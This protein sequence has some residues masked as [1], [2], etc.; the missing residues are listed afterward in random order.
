MRFYYVVNA[1]MP[2]EKAHGIQIAKMCEAFAEAGADIVLMVPRR[3]GSTEDLQ[4]F[5]ALRPSIPLIRL[6]VPDFYT[7]G[8]FGFFMSSLFFM[9][10]YSF[11]LLRRRIAGERF[12]IY[13]IDMDTFSF[14][15]LPLFGMCIT[16][17]H[18]PKK[19]TL[20]QKFF[21]HRVAGVISTTVLTKTALRNTFAF[22]AQRMIVEPNG[23]DVN[24]FASGMSKE[25]ARQK[26]SLPG[27]Q[28]IALY[29]GRV[30]AWKG[31]EVL[32]KACERLLASS[33]ECYVVG[34]T[35]E[36][37]EKLF[38][39]KLPR[40]MHCMGIKEVK[41]IPLW[42]AASDVALVV[43]TAQNID[44][45]RYTSPMK[46]FE[47]VA[48]RI[49]IVA[50]GTPALKEVLTEDDVLFYEPDNSESLAQNIIDAVEK[51]H[52][53]AVRTAHAFRKVQQYT[54]QKRAQRILAFCS[55]LS[56]NTIH[57]A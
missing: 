34:G 24:L 29:V 55:S 44:S 14:T 53:S 38:G 4:S 46:L 12:V 11:F 15:F 37:L 42:L 5:Y 8:R 30:Y 2:N 21:F 50:S 49:P 19:G 33:I 32:P 56:E 36:E 26:L 54:W 52:E 57:A 41:E 6:W 3:G 23:V 17:M 39:G 27:T 25:D 22:P 35:T 7:L 18:T 20:F 16:E 48:A 45:F 28:K 47:Y 43:G 40:N 10:R 31:L 13:T 9:L 51:S 1:R